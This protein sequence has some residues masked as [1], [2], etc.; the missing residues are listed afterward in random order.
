MTPPYVDRAEIDRRRRA[1]AE[2]TR[3]MA[4]HRAT[5]WVRARNG[6]ASTFNGGHWTWSRYSECRCGTCG[7]VWR[8]TAA[9]VAGLPD[10]PPVVTG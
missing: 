9:Y 6:N 4:E 7:R 3:C 1:R 5:W 10:K 8:T 2:T